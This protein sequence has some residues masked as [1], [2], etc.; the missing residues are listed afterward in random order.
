MNARQ[1]V[2]G[3]NKKFDVP[4][5]N[6]RS[7]G[8]IVVLLFALLIMWSSFYTISPEEVGVVQRFGRFQALAQPGLHYKIPLGIDAVSPI[9]VLRQQKM[10]FG[11]RT[12]RPGVRSVY[13][14][15]N[16]QP[17][18][19]DESLM[20]SGDLNMAIVEWIVQYR[21]NEPKDYLF[22]I[23]DPEKTLSD[24]AESVV[25]EVVG[26]RTIDEILTTGRQEM[27]DEALKRLQALM[28]NYQMGIKI[29]QVIPQDVTPPD[30]V[31]VSF[32]EVNQAQQERESLINVARSEYNKVIPLAQG[33]AL[34]K[35]QEA[36]GYAM[37]RVNEA[38]GDAIKFDTV[39]AAYLLA[40]E[41]TRR[42]IYLETMGQVIPKVG[43]KL[44]IDQDVKQ[45]LPL[46]SLNAEE[47]AKP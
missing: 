41:V 20:V 10:E 47:A 21:I 34:Q 9:K 22:R 3:P 25:R 29:D 45:L 6:G 33:E 37:Q 5:F 7:F 40:P 35:I 15:H 42:R 14:D 43:R 38:K 1:V 4:Q 17:S 31:K 46:L 12:T 24:A 13:I 19:L 16:Q 23:R 39:L 2:L 11:F 18:L 32:D 8:M 28:D 36:E 44:I 30:Q 26:D 27:A